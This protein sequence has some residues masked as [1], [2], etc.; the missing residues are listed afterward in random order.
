MGLLA[1]VAQVSAVPLWVPI[2]SSGAVVAGTAFAIKAWTAWKRSRR[3]LESI[4][5][6][7]ESTPAGEEA[8]FTEDEALLVQK[9]IRK[10]VH[11]GN[12]FQ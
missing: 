4:R 8:S 1:S 10:V 11:G 6:K 9:V 3:L 5:K 7:T 2:V 12:V